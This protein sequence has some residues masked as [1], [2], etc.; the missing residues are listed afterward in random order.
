MDRF[1]RPLFFPQRA[2]CAHPELPVIGSL[3][4][5]HEM[6]PQA[7]HQTRARARRRRCERRWPFAV[8]ERAGYRIQFEQTF[9]Q[10][11]AEFRLKES[12]ATRIAPSAEESMF[13]RAQRRSIFYGGSSAR[14]TSHDERRDRV[15]AH[16]H[17]AVFVTVSTERGTGRKRDRIGSAPVARDEGSSWCGR[18]VLRGFRIRCATVLRSRRHRD[19]DAPAAQPQCQ[20]ALDQAALSSISRSAAIGQT[21]DLYQSD[22]CRVRR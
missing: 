11:L 6:R 10:P 13:M 22:G 5:V 2:S 15:G 18:A 14:D 12:R 7:R 4:S 21:G 19:R 17:T 20:G 16:V 3:P 1:C 8:R 9:E